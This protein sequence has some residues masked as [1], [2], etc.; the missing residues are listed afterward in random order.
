MQKLILLI[1]FGV[2]GRNH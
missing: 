1:L 2:V